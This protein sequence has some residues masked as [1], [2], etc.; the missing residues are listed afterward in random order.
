MR[1]GFKASLSLVRSRRAD[2]VRGQK[3][4]IYGRMR[5]MAKNPRIERFQ[6]R[7]E[8]RRDVIVAF[9]R[10]KSVECSAAYEPER[11]IDLGYAAVGM[12]RRSAVKGP[13]SVNAH[14]CM[15]IDATAFGK[16]RRPKREG[17]IKQPKVQ[18]FYESYAW[19]KLRY[20]VL[21]EQG[22]SCALCNATRAHG[23]RMHVDHIRPLRKFWELRL[24]KA[25]LQ[26]LCEVCNHG[27]G[28]WDETDWRPTPPAA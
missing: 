10:S 5:I 17:S 24:E 6:A 7:I 2:Q 22:A 3:R 9:L 15:I 28:N 18:G 23:V 14:Y 27:K 8:R 16:K 13:E 20:E 25:N 11:L 26:I 21:A 1:A 19:R 4:V 12:Q